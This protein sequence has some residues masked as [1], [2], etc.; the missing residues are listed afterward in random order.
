M[1]NATIE[2]FD[3][4]AQIRIQDRLAKEPRLSQIPLAHVAPSPNNPRTTFDAAALAELAESLRRHGVLQPILVRTLPARDDSPVRYEIVAGERRWRAAQLA[5][6]KRVPAIVVDDEG[7]N[8]RYVALAE[9]LHREDL[10]AWEEAVTLKALQ[11]LTGLTYDAL[12]ARVGKSVDY[13][14]KRMRLLRY[15]PDV[16]EALQTIAGFSA[17]HADEINRLADAQERLGL[18]ERVRAGAVS[19]ADLKRA[20]QKKAPAKRKAAQPVQTPLVVWEEL[21]IEALWREHPKGVPAHLLAKALREDL[22]TCRRLLRQ[23]ASV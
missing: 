17:G 14:K 3:R 16:I 18:I 4:I 10:S 7:D 20:A 12:S 11:D 9:N 23:E 8:N 5:D 2:E 6:L 22:T 21:A 19:V 1:N 15:Q 13:V